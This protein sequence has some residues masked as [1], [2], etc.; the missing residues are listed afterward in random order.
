MTT[1]L[2][3]RL[4]DAVEQ[5]TGL[6]RIVRALLYENI[7]G[8]SRWRYVWG[9][10]LVFTFTVQL[11]TGFFL[12]LGYSP[13]AQ[14]AWESVYYLEHE[15][16]GGSLLRG[17]HHYTAQAMILLLVLHVL[18]VVID[19]AYRAPRELNFWI[20]L[21]LL[22]IVLAL[23]LTGY[24]LPWDQK[25]YW[26]TKVA[27]NLTAMTPV[28]GEDMKR[29][30]VG[31][32]EY[33][34]TTV[35][36]FFAMH[37]GLLPFLMILFTALHVYLFRRHGIHVRR[38]PRAPDTTFWPDQVLKDG[39]ACLAVLA[40]VLLL[41]AWQPAPLMAP[42]S[43]SEPYSAARPEWYFLFLFQLLKLFP[44]KSTIWGAIYIP[45]LVLLFMAL[46][47]ILGRWRLGHAFNVMFIF[48]LL[49]G[50]AFLTV[51]AVV[52]DRANEE[53][54]LA[55]RGAEADAKRVRVLA[56]DLGIPPAGAVTLLEADAL[57][58]GPKIFARHCAA[59]HRH[60]GEDGLG[61]TPEEAPS[62][63]DL[64]GFAS[65][66]W[67]TGLLD[68]A[69]I[70]TPHYFGATAFKD[71]DMVDFVKSTVAAYDPAR[72]RSLSMVTKALSAEAGLKSQR[73]LDRRDAAEIETG[74]LLLES[75][76]GDPPGLNCL[77]CHTFGENGK[78]GKG[79]DLT[80]YGSR[81]WLIDFI[82]DPAHE[83]FYSEENDRMP[84]YGAEEI[85]DR[86]SVELVADW[87][88]GEWYVPTEESA[89]PPEGAPVVQAPEDRAP[90]AQPP[91]AQAPAAQPA[92]T[93]APLAQPA[94]TEA[95]VEPA[96]AK[97]PESAS[98][99][100]ERR[101]EEDGAPSLPE[102]GPVDFAAHVQPILETHCV[103]CH[104]SSGRKPKGELRLD[105]RENALK[106]GESGD[107]PIT[108]GKSGESR[109]L[110]LIQSQDEEER[111]PPADI[112]RSLTP[113]E[114]SVLERWIDSGAPWPEGIVLRSR[115]S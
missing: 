110:R 32:A 8:G 65:R 37:A 67:L 107:P 63:S 81:D 27:T 68:P 2:L 5:R 40:A 98:E 108:P 69:R 66:Q 19:G 89:L 21:I 75:R 54:Q 86:R 82:S 73:E 17:I 35:T 62:A 42:A 88:R 71:G 33:G 109:V 94:V 92:V 22:L 23:G 56:R 51:M 84:R 79:P 4:G 30:V 112:G 91:V 31:G 58:Q 48:S 10:T 114:V 102:S 76:R 111:M 25:G 47:P 18:Q 44:G 80:G 20:G 9:S 87:L 45:G 59:C 101:P 61:K 100:E 3:R 15:T 50:A 106:P 95:P 39:V 28:V 105:T 46:M 14:T 72:A 99:T 38:S 74:R 36:R 1:P 64:Q 85:L 49:G 55:V 7:P 96:P 60:G 93:E 78:A 97:T 34:H 104:G 113:L 11:I 52:Q 90:V 26:A 12:W 24:L 115:G 57:T 77:R 41:A 13:S 16:A 83:R 103:K 43:P 29:V 70:D 6:R 53:Y